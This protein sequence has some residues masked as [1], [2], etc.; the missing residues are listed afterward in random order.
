[1]LYKLSTLSHGS[2]DSDDQI[3]SSPPDHI[4]SPLE[5]C[6]CFCNSLCPWSSSLFCDTRTWEAQ[7]VSALWTQIYTYNKGVPICSSCIHDRCIQSATS[8]VSQWYV[9]YRGH[10]SRTL[11]GPI[12]LMPVLLVPF[13][14]VTGRQESSASRGCESIP[15]LHLLLNVAIHF[16]CRLKRWDV[17]LWVGGGK[18]GGSWL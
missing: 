4:H 1:M 5:N 13:V 11:L 16:L 15:E 12:L 3:C 18:K 7:Q 8:W 9:N 14:I 10:S 2:G 6:F 17:R